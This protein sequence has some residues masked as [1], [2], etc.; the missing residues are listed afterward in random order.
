MTG[1]FPDVEDALCELLE[2]I[3]PTMT[4]LGAFLDPEDPAAGPQPPCLVINRVGGSADR[5]GLFDTARVEI[6]CFGT[7]RAE[8]KDLNS[9]VRQ[10]MSDSAEGVSTEAGLLDSI[11]EDGSPTPIPYGL[12]YLNIR[13]QVSNWVVETRSR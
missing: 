3:A 10:K 2:D 8:S 11:D 5:Q 9:A 1:D 7:S 12:E 6:S 13:R 4:D